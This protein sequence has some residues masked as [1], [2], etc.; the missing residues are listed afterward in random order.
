MVYEKNN[1]ILWLGSMEIGN[2][3]VVRWND[4]VYI[5]FIH[6]REKTRRCRFYYTISR[7]TKAYCIVGNNNIIIFS[8]EASWK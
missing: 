3:I 7:G 4:T 1:N 6:V 8:T 2:E 5:Y